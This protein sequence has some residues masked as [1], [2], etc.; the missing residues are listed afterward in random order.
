VTG[1]GRAT[2]AGLFGLHTRGARVEVDEMLPGGGRAVDT[3]VDGVW[4]LVRLRT[5]ID[6][7]PSAPGAG[8]AGVETRPVSADVTVWTLPWP[9]LALATIL[10]ALLLAVRAVIRRRRQRLA[11]LLARARDEGREEGRESA[12]VG[13]PPKE[14][15]S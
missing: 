15:T 12:L 2:V 14:S 4:A 10:M 8:P 3:R 13:K 5:T 7:T 1:T 6:L 9:Q 11:N